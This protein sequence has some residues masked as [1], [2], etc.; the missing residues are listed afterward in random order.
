MYLYP[1]INTIPLDDITV[2]NL[3]LERG[4][5]VAP[6]SAFGSSYGKFIRISATQTTEQIA[7]AMDV[8]D[9]CLSM[10]R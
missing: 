2:V 6:G 10:N 3:L 1:R 7:K 5:A 9:N 4:V 8:L